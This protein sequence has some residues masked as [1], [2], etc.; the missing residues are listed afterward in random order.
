MFT[1]GDPYVC[2]VWDRCQVMDTVTVVIVS[3][4]L[5]LEDFIGTSELL[6]VKA[7]E[8]QGCLWSEG[9]LSVFFAH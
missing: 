2:V 8:L 9:V 1:S 3:F 5:L 4:L 7:I 6:E